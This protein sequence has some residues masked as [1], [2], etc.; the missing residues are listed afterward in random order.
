MP[1]RTSTHPAIPG[2]AT[3][4]LATP[5]PCR[6]QPCPGTP[7]PCG[8]VPSRGL[9]A[10]AVL[11]PDRRSKLVGVFLEVR[12]GLLASRRLGLPLQEIS[13]CVGDGV[14]LLVRRRLE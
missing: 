3:A 11:Q 9:C 10:L 1:Y 7:S 13:E 12:A 4:L 5:C 14:Q 8:P 2:L 6:T